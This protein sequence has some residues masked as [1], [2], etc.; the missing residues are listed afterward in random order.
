MIPVNELSEFDFAEL[1]RRNTED[2][3]EEFE[4]AQERLQEQRRK[5][6][7][8]S[9]QL[10]ERTNHKLLMADEDPIPSD[11][12]KRETK[13]QYYARQPTRSIQM[14]LKFSGK[15]ASDPTASF[16]IQYRVYTDWK[17]SGKSISKKI[18][19]SKNEYFVEAIPKHFPKANQTQLDIIQDAEFH[20]E[21][22]RRM[23]TANAAI[24]KVLLARARGYEKA[25]DAMVM[26]QIKRDEELA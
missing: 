3:R 4:S 26:K 13:N 8:L 24:N 25:T 19:P 14:F 21:R 10:V 1:M 6:R 5:L 15:G 11:Q 18:A 20:A 17:P 7:E 23:L 12:I 2:A 16:S 9:Q 22:L